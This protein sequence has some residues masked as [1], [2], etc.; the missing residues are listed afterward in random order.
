MRC[1]I[2]LAGGAGTVGVTRSP[3]ILGIQGKRKTTQKRIDPGIGTG[4]LL[5]LNLPSY[6]YPDVA[7]GFAEQDLDEYDRVADGLAW[8]RS[9][10]V[11]RLAFGTEV[12]IEKTWEEN[13]ERGYSFTNLRSGGSLIFFPQISSIPGRSIV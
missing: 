4:G 10:Q 6:T 13:E 8:S 9:L 3:E 2:H 1:L 11:A 7:P 5:K 12:P